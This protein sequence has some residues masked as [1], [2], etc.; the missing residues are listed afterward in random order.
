V[1]IRARDLRVLE[2]FKANLEAGSGGK[3]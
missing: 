2:F 1:A 3:N